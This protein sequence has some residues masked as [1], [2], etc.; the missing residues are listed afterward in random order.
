LNVYKEGK[1]TRLNLIKHQDG[2]MGQSAR[3]RRSAAILAGANLPVTMKEQAAKAK[4]KEGNSLA[5]F[6]QTA[7]F[8][9]RALNQVLV[10][11]LIRSAQP[12]MR[13]NDVILGI[14]FNY[15]RR[16]VKLYS[17]AWSASEAHRLYINLQDQI[18]N[19]IQVS[20][21]LNAQCPHSGLFC[22]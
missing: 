20:L 18:R 3:P 15:S 17:R 10:M 4:K 8:D 7:L 19:T 2:D 13:I 21:S 6:V 11:W 16:G 12:W 1:D 9:N 14:S 5:Q 22:R